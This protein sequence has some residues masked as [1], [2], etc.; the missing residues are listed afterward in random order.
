MAPPQAKASWAAPR[1]IVPALP[2]PH[3]AR[4]RVTRLLARAAARPILVVTGPAG[5][6][7]TTAVA[8]WIRTTVSGPVAWL[9]M[10]PG[11]ADPEHFADSLRRAVGMAGTNETGELRSVL[12]AALGCEGVLVVDDVPPPDRTPRLLDDLVRWPPDGIRLVLVC[13]AGPPPATRRH[14]L[15]RTLGSVGSAE[16]AFTREELDQLL[17]Q[18]GL[19]LPATTV[20]RLLDETEGWTAP[21]LESALGGG[22]L[23]LGA[24]SPL[25]D[26]L[27]H[28]V[29][30][31]LPPETR[32]LLLAT[33]L[34]PRVDLALAQRLTDR[35]GI[36]RPFADLV[37][38]ELLLPDDCGRLHVRSLLARV[39]AGLLRFEQPALEQRI[40]RA[41]IVWHETDNDHVAALRQAVDSGNW[42]DVGA[43]V[44]R[45]SATAIFHPQRHEL[46]AL[47]KRIPY[48]AAFDNPELEI[49]GALASFVAREPAALWTQLARAD[50]RLDTLPEPR[51]SIAR[52][53]SRILE[54]SQAYRDGDAE[55]TSAAAAEADRLLAGLSA[56]QAPGWAQNRGIPQG[57]LAA[58]EIWAGRPTR[59]LEVLGA[60]VA[61]YPGA[62]MTG[63]VEVAYRAQQAVAEMG[64]GLLSRARVSARASVAS[65]AGA[66]AGVVLE[67]QGAW[68]AL[69]VGALAQG[70][71][72]RASAA[73]TEA[74]TAAG[75]HLHPTVEAALLL[76]AAR[77]AL[78]RNDPAA[79]HRRLRAAEILLERHP[80]MVAIAQ[81]ATAL[82]IRLD[83][84]AGSSVAA[85]AA[86]TAA[87]ESG[88]PDGDLLVPARISLALAAGAPERALKLADP[89]L[90]RAGAYGALGWLARAQALEAQRQDSAATESLARALDLAAAEEAVLPFLRPDRRL[91]SMLTR[92]LALV[93]THHEL[94]GRAL[95]TTAPAGPATYGRLTP[96]ELS[97][98]AYLPTMGSNAEIA[99][100][101]HLSENT[102]KQHLKTAYRKL[103]VG[104]RRDAVRVARQLGLL[105]G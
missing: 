6:G 95:P 89:L 30:D 39:I 101:L 67:T 57:L 7:K 37:T 2:V 68:L 71:P 91:T 43:L 9:S 38:R 90:G 51:H 18:Q 100:A 16:L 64:A 58:G 78:L 19:D 44:V 62:A 12:A 17:V 74:R 53:T 23:D 73:I 26:Y 96:R 56:D 92:H 13:P 40:R 60:S 11:D 15:A 36:L 94:V 98:V 33:A 105:P 82:R 99:A 76:V 88:V 4:P 32:E 86:Y 50:Q 14:R 29:L 25:A 81:G 8:D 87:R 54:A 45:S 72:D 77:T 63:Y 24:G 103:G 93:S 84:R 20:G 75:P 80:G 59:A 48:E 104:N 47:L 52:L 3:L 27:H 10:V 41:A 49:C 5:T 1:F 66:A 65:A 21:L 97:V 70:D 83:L 35:E 102:V 79:A 61:G 85:G 55:R 22:E 31:P 69:A 46:H 42:S 28:E 34:V